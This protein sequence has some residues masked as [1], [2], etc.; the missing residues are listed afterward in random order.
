MSS[1][2]PGLVIANLA[3][4]G[5][6]AVPA[7]L[8]LRAGLNVLYGASNTG[9]SFAVKTIDFMLGSARPLPGIEEREGY[10]RVWLAATL[11][12]LR[13]VTLMRALA[14]GSFELYAGHVTA[15]GEPGQNVRQISARHD[16]TNTDN[17]SQLLLE[18]LGFGLKSIAIDPNGKKRSLSFRD[19]ARFCIVD[20]TAIQSEASPAES[21]QYATVTAERSVFKLLTTGLDDSAIVPV[22]DRRTFRTATTA[23]L[24]VVDE[25]ITTI[26]EELAADFPNAEQLPEQYERLE[27]SWTTAQHEVQAAQNSI[28][29]RLAA[30]R[31]LAATISRHEERGAEIAINLERFAQ[32][33]RVYRSDIERLE[34]IEEAGFL[35]ALGGDKNC[36]LCG[37]PPDA[38]RHVHGL[39]DIEKARDAARAEIDKISRQSIDLRATIEQLHIEGQQT[40]LR[41]DE[42]D[43]SLRTLEAELNELAPA[44]DS[45]KRRL[46]EALSVRDHVRRG[47]TLLDQKRALQE[48]R[49]ELAALR[50]ASKSEKPQLG[51]S[52][53]AAHD[54]SQSVSAVLQQWRFPGNRHVSFDEATCDLLIDGKRRRDNGKGVRAITHAAFKFAL[55]IFCRERG[56]PHPGILVLD[57]PLLTYRD[58]LRSPAGALDP[59]EQAIK[60]TPLKDFFFQHLS[61]IGEMGQLLIVEN[62]D[63]PAN[64]ATLAHVVTFTGHSTTGRAGLFPSRTQ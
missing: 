37:A 15:P 39:A 45:A 1:S 30:K 53:T 20:E 52:A 6:S 29:S 56:L 33:E 10:E 27:E 54:F 48:R 22:V 4:T 63:L 3:F 23:K 36:P 12:Q 9:K 60:N 59:D 16:H 43:R 62:V 40:E 57:S 31:E 28:R 47:L 32:L 61:S 51:V 19:L 25:M 38:Q 5:A 42:L 14:G 24:E 49:N 46:D 11:P 2:P 21:G 26:T 35:L 18:E 34:T 64:I 50:P 44:A 7:E 8:P 55:L 17:I 13:D 41:L 58:P